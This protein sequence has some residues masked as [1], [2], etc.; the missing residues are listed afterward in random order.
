MCPDARVKFNQLS[1]EF[2]ALRD[3]TLFR[4]AQLTGEELQH[5][6]SCSLVMRVLS[7]LNENT[8]PLLNFGEAAEKVLLVI[9]PIEQSRRSLSN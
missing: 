8:T 4:K 1:V 7:L 6:H 2:M 9:G 3:P 5:C